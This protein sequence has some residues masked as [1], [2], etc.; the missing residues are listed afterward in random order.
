MSDRIDSAPPEFA[1]SESDY[2]PEHP[3]GRVERV[4][5]EKR[6]LVIHGNW[7]HGASNNAS[8]VAVRNTTLG[9]G[10]G[11]FPDYIRQSTGGH[12]RVI[13][14]FVGDL[15]LGARPASCDYSNQLANA[16]RLAQQAGYDYRD[17]D[18]TFFAKPYSSACNWGGLAA[19]PGNWSIAN[20]NGGSLSVWSHEF[21]HNLGFAHIRE[22]IDCPMQDEV[23]DVDGCTSRGGGGDTG[24]TMGS[25]G[26]ARYPTIYRSFHGWWNE[27]ESVKITR[28]GTYRLGALGTSGVQ[29]LL[30]PVAGGDVSLEYRRR[31]PQYET[32]DPIY[33]EG[34]SMRQPRVSGRVITNEIIDGSPHITGLHKV[35][36]LG[37]AAEFRASGLKV[38]TCALTE[39]HAE[40]AV[41]FHGDPLPN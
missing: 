26:T 2:V 25:G 31:D 37:R 32:R 22:R 9:D 16:R 39:S 23:V 21:G 1:P 14:D 13:G 12:L 17:Y 29:E 27:Q 24:D 30:L 18:Y 6:F 10:T 19:M 11:R 38:K 33:F 41:A 34:I 15:D 28:T 35:L 36:Q 40:V 3:E 7:S 20:G 4:S 5:G 8:A